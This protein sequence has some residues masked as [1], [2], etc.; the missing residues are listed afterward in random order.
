MRYI[1]MLESMKIAIA[2]LDF[3]NM[4]SM[5]AV[6]KE[7]RAAARIALSFVSGSWTT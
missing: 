6:G 4:R 3:A 7:W 1:G 5:P 2:L